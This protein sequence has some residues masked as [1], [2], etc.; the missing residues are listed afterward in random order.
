MPT[1]FGT[2]RNLSEVLAGARVTDLPIVVQSEAKNVRSYGFSMPN[3][4]KLIA[5][6]SDGVA[7]DDDPGTAS[8]VILPDY[9]GQTATG[10]DV[11]YGFEQ[12]L[13]SS[14]KNGDLVVP[15]F[16]LKDYPI[17]VRLSK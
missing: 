7:A 2:I 1:V 5:L 3:G 11:L 12:E 8:T 4:D 10:I 14:N 17:F 13:M 6:W 16:M 15:V 9:S